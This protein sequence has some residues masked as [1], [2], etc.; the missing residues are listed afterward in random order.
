MGLRKFKPISSRID[1][2]KEILDLVT[3]RERIIQI[4]E[5]SICFSREHSIVITD[6]Y[7][8]NSHH[9]QGDFYNKMFIM[10]QRLQ[11]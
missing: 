7:N 4:S 1:N 3:R 10:M 9:C 5:F 8:I 11:C 6:F 2:N